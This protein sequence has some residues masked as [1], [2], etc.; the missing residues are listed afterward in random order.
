MIRKIPITQDHIKR[1]TR[2]NL[3][4]CPIA[5]AVRDAGFIP[6]SAG[7]YDITVNGKKYETTTHVYEWM[8]WYDQHEDLSEIEERILIL[9][10]ETAEAYFEEEE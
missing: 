7:Y 1:G 4:F 3:N 9:D 10:D 5:L 6:V 2:R 8:D